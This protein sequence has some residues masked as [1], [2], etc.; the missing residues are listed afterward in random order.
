[1]WV[2]SAS[3]AVHEE[4]VL[5]LAVGRPNCAWRRAATE[6]LATHSR[7]YRILFTS[8]SAQVVIAA[9][10]GGLA[11]SVL[12]ECAL[13]PG[14]RVLGEAEGFA[15]LPDV[16]IGILRGHSSRPEIV[17]ALARHIAE[18]LDNISVPPIEAGTSF[19]F[20]ALAFARL[21]KQTK[22]LAGW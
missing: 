13:R 4:A 11:V 19:D 14:M 17:E 1:L 15:P 7:E 9:V 10:L 8:W 22:A 16:Q 21:K 5:P 20:E 3:H 2:T 12:P 6:Q 18:S